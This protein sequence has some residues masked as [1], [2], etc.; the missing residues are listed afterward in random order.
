SAEEPV[1]EE[2]ELTSLEIP[3]DHPK[4]KELSEKEAK[5]RDEA[6]KARKRYQ[7]L[8]E[9][10]QRDADE[11]SD[12]QSEEETE[13]ASEK[14]TEVVFDPEKLYQEFASRL[15]N[16]FEAREAQQKKKKEA[17]SSVIKEFKLPD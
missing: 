12:S 4:L 14:K 13:E 10:L 3:E 6:I 17:V 8:R 16:D 9:Q 15:F 7:K 1:Y 5:A 2:V 11:G